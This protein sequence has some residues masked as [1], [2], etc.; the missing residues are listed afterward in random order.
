MLYAAVL[1]W[2]ST[3]AVLSVLLVGVIATQSVARAVRRSTVAPPATP[4]CEGPASLAGPQ[5]LT[6]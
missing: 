4:P 6:S 1:L 5:L 3:T 2:V